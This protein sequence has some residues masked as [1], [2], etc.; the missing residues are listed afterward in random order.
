MV[1]EPSCQL[2]TR[3]HAIL[4]EMLERHTGP[5]TPFTRLLERKLRSSAICFR[6]DI[7]PGVVTLNTRLTY[8]VNGMPT[9][10]HL[11]VPGN[12]ED[13]PGD[14][15]SIDTVRGLAL[16]GLP[17]GA[18]IT[19][20][21]ADDAVEKLRVEKVFPQVA[22]SAM[23]QTPRSAIQSGGA[24]RPDNVVSFHRARNVMS[25]TASRGPDDD[26]PGPRAA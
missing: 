1:T 16:L 19:V 11:L 24:S 3:D 10:P 22:G 18:A 4:Q 14:A 9:G 20:A 23:R 6:D 13:L 5:Y 2:T 25:F 21:L 15:L 7:P 8:V 26:D 12:G 17:E